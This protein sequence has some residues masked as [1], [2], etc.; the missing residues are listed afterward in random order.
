MNL[1]I[2]PIFYLDTAL[3]NPGLSSLW[4]TQNKY[5]DS[6]DVLYA[7]VFQ[8]SSQYQPSGSDPWGNA[9]IPV[10]EYLNY[11][12]YV[13]GNES[14]IVIDPYS[15]T[16]YSSY[17][18]IP[19]TSLDEYDGGYDGTWNLTMYSSY[20]YLDCPLLHFETMDQIVVDLEKI[21]MTL[22]Q[23]SNDTSGSLRMDMA[24]P[25]TDYPVG[26]VTFISSCSAAKSPDGSPTYAYSVCNLSQTF[27]DSYVSCADF[28]CTVVNITKRDVQPTFMTDFIPEF[29]KSSDTGLSDWLVI[30]DSVFSITELYIRNSSNATEPGSG[31][32]CDLATTNDA[33][34]FTTALSYLMNT[35]YSTGFTD[36][37]QAGSISPNENITL[38][39]GTD[40][41]TYTVYLTN[42]ANGTHHYRSL[43]APV[44]YKIHCLFIVIFEFCAV[45]LLLIGIAGVLLESRTISPDI[46]GFASNLARHSKYV[47]LPKTDS[48]M[49]G[50]ECARALGN[51]KVMMQ[52]MK[53][54]AEVGKI[55]LGTVHESAQRLRPGRLYR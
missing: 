44:V 1:T 5:S 41:S 20:L 23:L 47:K 21:N 50:G 46:L 12:Y 34:S 54:N 31:D 24:P 27:V 2:Q 16:K 53:P 17:Y 29:L 3:P 28:N 6:M 33:Q 48:T 49:S 13:P 45:T 39:N 8:Q 37:F 26:N 30:G 18:G 9:L 11:S 35:F 36:D 10:Y 51:V 7:A 43:D 40:G 22:S 14:I 19:L 25:T 52:D 4:E 42:H 55:V 15:V 38:G 32:Y